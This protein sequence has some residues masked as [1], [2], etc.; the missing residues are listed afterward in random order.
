LT[1]LNLGAPDRPGAVLGELL[2]AL[3]GGTLVTVVAALWYTS[4][5]W[6]I[7]DFSLP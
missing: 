5:L 7:N 3:A 1:P 6:N 4:A 2:R